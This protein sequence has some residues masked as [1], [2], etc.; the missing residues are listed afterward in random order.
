M[1]HGAYIFVGPAD[2]FLVKQ[3]TDYRAFLILH[4]LI[5]DSVYQYCQLFSSS[6]YVFVVIFS[7]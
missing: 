5:F 3:E 4:P 6:E 1:N 2:F 7:L